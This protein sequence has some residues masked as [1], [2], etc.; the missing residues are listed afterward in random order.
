MNK[1]LIG[2]LLFQFISVI[3]ASYD[4]GRPWCETC[5]S[6]QI[7]DA[8]G[9]GF[10][11]TPSYGTASVHYYN[12]TVVEVGHVQG[13]PEYLELMKRLTRDSRLWFDR[14]KKSSILSRFSLSDT[15]AWGAWW[16]WLNKKL[17]SPIKAHNDVEIISELLQVLQN[18]TEKEISQPLDRVA[19]TTPDL[20]S[21]S[22]IVN[23]ALGDLNLRTWVGDS[24]F[25]PRSLAEADAVFAANEYGL[26]I[27]YQDLWECEQEF[28][29]PPFPQVFTIFY[30]RH[31]L[32]T[33]IMAPMGGQALSRY[34]F[35]DAQLL[36]FN[37]GLDNLLQTNRSQ[38]SLWPHLRS[39]LL[40]LPRNY[41][42]S[43]THNFLAGESVTHPR[44]LATLRDAMAEIMP[45][46]PGNLQT[47]I[48][49]HAGPAVVSKIVDP[50]FAASRGAA[51]YA[52]RRQ[53]VQAD[54]TERS[55]CE[56]TRN[57]ERVPLSKKEDLR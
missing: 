39:Q 48:P 8:P 54:C 25:Y 17:G 40:V 29:K 1:L 33:S 53:E 45:T 7:H 32:Y 44:F 19:V 41:S 5:L 21:I 13:N 10:D 22:S 46:W 28:G 12:G 27:N 52:R 36:D 38:E 56:A 35:D 31:L 57:E 42:R 50:T 18:S 23:A 26:C 20:S 49:D 4:C 15:T 34:N 9:I 16:R 37:L 6:T 2:F 14:T 51:L 43:I 47:N 24:G 11:L 3:D 55:T 30:S